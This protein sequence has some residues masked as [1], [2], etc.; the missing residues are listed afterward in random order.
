[1]KNLKVDLDFQSF[2]EML[3]ILFIA[4]KLAGIINWSWFWVLAP[5]EIVL[6]IVVVVLIFA[7]PY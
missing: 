3:Q 4:F 7:W 5:M 6:V 2:G 1:M